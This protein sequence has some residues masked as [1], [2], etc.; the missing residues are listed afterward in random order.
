MATLQEQ[1][2]SMYD[3]GQFEPFITHIR[4]PKYKNLAP[5]TKIDFLHPVTAL[6]GSNGTNKSSILRALYGVPDYSNLGNLWFST[7]IDPIIEGDGER[8]CF[9]YGHYN[10]D[11]KKITEVLKIRIKK[12]NDTD[13]WEPSRPYSKYEMEMIPR[14]GP[15]L[16]GA[17][18]TRWNPIKKEMLYIDFRSALSAFDK[19]FYYGELK[20]KKSTYKEKK[21][22]LR[23]RSPHLKKA[24]DLG[25]TTLNYR[26]SERIVNSENSLL[27]KEEL[28][29][30][31]KILGRE[32]SEIRLIRHRLYNTDGYT[33]RLK[34]NDFTYTEAFAGSGEFAVIKLVHAVMQCEA[35]TLILLDEP[36][37]SL[38]P[39]AQERLMNFLSEQVK[40]LKHQ[41]IIST[42]SPS[43]IRN[44]PSQAIKVLAMDATS[45]KIG[46]AR[47][48]SLPEEAFF[49]LGE[50]AAGKICV[51]VEDQ[52]AKAIVEKCLRRAGEAFF[53]LFEVTYFPGGCGTLWAHY[54]PIFAAEQRSNVLV[55]L[56]GDQRP[57][58]N[59]WFVDPDTIPPGEYG[60]LPN[61]I[62]SA[63][64]VNIEFHTDGGKDGGNGDQ[65]V[66]AQINFIK[67]AKENVDFMPDL[68]PEKFV[69]LR[70][71]EASKKG[72]IGKNYKQLFLKLTKIELG[73]EEY[74]KVTSTEILNTQKRL[75]A[76]VSDD[77]EELVVLR[78]KLTEFA[79]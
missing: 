53:R 14:G 20:D 39:G 72:V 2:K 46:L 65:L 57:K 25:L 34:T 21:D 8:N 32:Y 3:A 68:T 36:E 19:F 54:L 24:A 38:H 10:V 78:K 40:V 77:D 45:G 37:V 56:D 22:F 67:W 55:L 12:E 49:H 28:N 63:T 26:K 18:L 33:A 44:L 23:T 64:G 74:E 9:I 70:A 31:S 75:L 15:R 48:E 51:V 35:C 62:K 1:L 4:F 58:G 16:P 7:S 6:V 66:K 47:Q 79:K 13:Y 76:L 11:A 29:E 61:I 71:P 52:L 5:N 27:S 73:L 17:S 41:V 60:K 30:I 43:L 69:W 50:P 42:H 59:N